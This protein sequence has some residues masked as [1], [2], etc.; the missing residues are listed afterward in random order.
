MLPLVNRNVEIAINSTQ[1]EA[2]QKLR[3]RGPR[4]LMRIDFY[5]DIPEALPIIQFK[6]FNIAIPIDSE[7]GTSGNQEIFPTVHIRNL[8]SSIDVGGLDFAE[9]EGTIAHSASSSID[10]PSTTIVFVCE[11]MTDPAALKEV[12]TGSNILPDMPPIGE[13]C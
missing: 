1:T 12:E 11:E 13:D 9:L 8:I 10:H 3:I 4:S 2:E 6:D 5:C 7:T